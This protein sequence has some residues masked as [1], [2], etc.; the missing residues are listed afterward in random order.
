MKRKA[1]IIFTKLPRPGEVKTRLG[2]SIGMVDAAR[3][4][5]GFA[6]HVFAIADELA[7]EKIEVCLYY[8]PTAT[9]EAV[10][11][12]V[13]RD[14]TYV[15]QRGEG[16][17]ERMHNAFASVFE[18]GVGR[19]IVIGTDVPEL[20]ATHVAKSFALLDDNDIVVGPSADGG[21]YLLGMNAPMKELFENIVWSSNTVFDATMAK[22]RTLGLSVTVLPLLHDI[23]TEEDLRQLERRLQNRA[24]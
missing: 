3:A 9:E 21:Y 15:P 6:E 22:V 12:W 17:G 18:D 16:L 20:E 11:A 24:G 7:R 4:Y 5:K 14:F 1:L 23:D 10:R 19:A 8:E 2:K 13:C